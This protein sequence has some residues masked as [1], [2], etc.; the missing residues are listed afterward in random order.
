MS[1]LN[2]GWLHKLLNKEVKTVV[3]PDLDYMIV[4]TFDARG[5]TRESRARES[6]NIMKLSDLLAGI[7]PH[8]VKAGVIAP[9]GAEWISDIGSGGTL[10]I[11]VT[12]VTPFPD[13]N[14]SPYIT[15]SWDD[16]YTFTVQE[17]TPNGFKLRCNSSLNP[18]KAPVYWGAIKHGEY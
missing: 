12:F 4:G 11:Q 2:I 9:E 17:V 6:E 5:K 18:P 16:T 15:G 10:Y 3:D 8:P 1:K 13:E 7:T 14:Y